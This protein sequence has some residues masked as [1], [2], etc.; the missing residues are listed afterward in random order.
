MCNKL[1]LLATKKSFYSVYILQYE[2][3]VHVHVYMHVH[4]PE[5]GA[6]IVVRIYIYIDTL[7]YSFCLED[8]VIDVFLRCLHN[9][10]QY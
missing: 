10:L 8:S 4:L 5:Q 7:P 2:F 9:V 3:L 6:T 1:K